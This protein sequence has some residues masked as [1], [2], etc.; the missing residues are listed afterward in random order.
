MNAIPRSW[1][2]GRRVTLALLAFVL[3]GAYAVV[4]TRPGT[5]TAAADVVTAAPAKGMMPAAQ[6]TGLLAA[7]E[8]VTGPTV[9]AVSQGPDLLDIFGVDAG[10]RIY[11]ASWRPDDTNGWHHSAQLVGGVAA[12]GTAVH[13]ISRFDG[14]LDAFAVGTDRRVYTSLKDPGVSRG[15]WQGW[16]AL[17]NLVVQPNSSVH[18]VK[19]NR[20]WMEIFAVGEDRKVY[21]A[22]WTTAANAWSPWRAVPG[23]TA[24]PNSTVYG[25]S[26]ANF[27]FDIFA[28]ASNGAP[29][30]NSWSTAGWTGWR[31]ISP[32]LLAGT[33]SLYPVRFAPNKVAIFGVG[34]P[35]ESNDPLFHYEVMT[36]TWDRAADTWTPMTQIRGGRTVWGATVFA[37]SRRTD[38]L[39]VFVVGTDGRPATA[40]WNPTEGWKGWWQIGDPVGAG[41]S[42]FAHSRST[43]QLDIF[44]ISPNTGTYT[45]GWSPSTGWGCWCEVG[46]Y[47]QAGDAIEVTA[48]VDFNGGVTVD[49]WTKLMVSATGAWSFRGHFHNSGVLSYN[50]GYSSLIS[51]PSGKGF[52][53]NAKGKA[54]GDLDGGDNVD[55]NRAGVDPALAAAWPEIRASGEW[56]WKAKSSL[57]VGALLNDLMVAAAYA[58]RALEVISAE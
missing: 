50:V 31:R 13:A 8:E 32:E 3:V 29:M 35:I 36:A 20:D 52:A 18:A 10:H 57:D 28:V 30:V 26:L 4:E 39:D 40:A 25:L 19:V 49:G 43:D 27:S 12:P 37:T 34:T 22:T 1:P 14:R 2:T 56:S 53:F 9:T 24:A 17:G 42:V 54:E 58:V 15:A 21:N 51:L 38:Q 45:R 55:F 7:A 48:H 33:G 46:P 44:A 5:T 47:G 11:H 41:T 16:W 23:I 6:T